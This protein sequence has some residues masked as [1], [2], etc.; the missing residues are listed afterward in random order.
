M[1]TNTG[2]AERS[3][4]LITVKGL[5]ESKNKTYQVKLVNLTDRLGGDAIS[6]AGVAPLVSG[7]TKH[8]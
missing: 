8:N 3:D 5:R 7:K 2:M 6:S 1:Q 4:E